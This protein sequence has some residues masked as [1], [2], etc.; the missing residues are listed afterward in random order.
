M[1]HRITSNDGICDIALDYQD[2][3]VDLSQSMRFAGSPEAA[4]AYVPIMDADVR[5]RYSHMFPQPEA[6]EGEE[7]IE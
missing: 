3:G 1:T 6:E 7:E 4:E 2:E 5:D